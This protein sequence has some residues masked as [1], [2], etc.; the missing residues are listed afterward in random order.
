MDDKKGTLT[1]NKEDKKSLDDAVEKIMAITTTSEPD[2]ANDIAEKQPIKLF[3]SG[4][5]NM[6]ANQM[7]DK[8]EEFLA[9]AKE[10]YPKTIYEQLI[11]DFT[12]SK[13][14]FQNS[15]E[16]DF[17]SNKGIYNFVAMFT[18]KEGKKTSSFNGTGFSTKELDKQ[19]K[20]CAYLDT[21]LKQ[22]AEQIDTRSFPGKIQGDIIVTPHCLDD[23]IRYITSYLQDYPLI[24]KTSIY[25]D[26][27]NKSI[28]DEKFTL[29]SRPVSDEIADG[30]FI[31]GDGFE[32][33][34]ST[35]I[36]NGILKTFLLSLYGANKTGKPKAVNSGGCYI[37]ETGDITHEDMIKNVK[38]GILLCRFSCGNPNDNGDFS[39]VAKNSYYIKNGKIRYPL[40]E[41][42]I[43]GNLAEM[44]NNIEN[45]SKNRID[46]GDSILPWM[47]FKDLTIFG[48]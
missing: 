36:D 26:K 18:S 39:G 23:F 8:L 47:H 40:D 42:M 4:P 14:Y 15:N 20:D 38:D 11:L 37:I 2:S 27:L 46:F 48:K 29:H 1:I 25:K 35:I 30:Y 19:L 21:L 43:S 22:S 34:N 6:D 13:V 3:E 28:A 5:S 12:K 24:T 44:L 32:A 45:I 10:K 9:Y 16:V 41:T 7:Y 17:Q 31:T 33:K